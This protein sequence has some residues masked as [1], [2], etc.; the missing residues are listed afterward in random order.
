MAVDPGEWKSLKLNKCA[1]CPHLLEDDP[2]LH[3]RR[4]KSG[5]CNT[6]DSGG[7]PLSYGQ[8]LAPGA[9][10]YPQS[11]LILPQVMVVRSMAH[12]CFILY[13]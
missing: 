2:G 12:S 10:L 8:C 4:P 13:Q 9:L 3:S 1:N 7:P 5:Q 11:K 6:G